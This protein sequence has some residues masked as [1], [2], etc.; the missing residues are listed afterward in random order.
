MLWFY[1]F[2]GVLEGSSSH[3]EEGLIDVFTG[4]AWGF[5]IAGDAELFAYFCGSLASYLTILYVVELSADK[6]DVILCVFRALLFKDMDVSLNRVQTL[7][8][9]QIED[10]Q[11]TLAIS[12]IGTS[13]WKELLLALGIPDL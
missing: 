7:L 11:G 5:E 9:G 13:Q 3:A 2:K 4:G 10:D 6:H 12:E 1:C 8:I